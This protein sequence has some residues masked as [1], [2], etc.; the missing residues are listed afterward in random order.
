[1][2][3]KF[4]KREKKVIKKL[5]MLSFEEMDT[6]SYFL[7]CHFFTPKSKMAFIVF[8]KINQGI[9]YIQNT[10]FANNE[11]RKRI[12]FHFLELIS[13][14]NYLENLRYISFFRFNDSIGGEMYLM[15]SEFKNPIMIE[16]QLFLNEE[17]Y[18]MCPDYSL[19]YKKEN[20]TVVY[21]SITIPEGIFEE[22]LEKYL[23]IFLVSEELR[24]L[25]R[26][27]FKTPEEIRFNKQRTIA[28]I[29]IG[30]SVLLG[31][32]SVFLAC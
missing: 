28:W 13:L 6:F 9:L 22:F 1:M 7:Q 5:A 16:N 27:D 4:N 3:R 18:F 20:N 2:I 14:I 25:V 10:L 31:I 21:R 24:E 19:I 30:V 11:K 32:I 29:G 12:Y 23:G 8:P 15:G 17:E 26:N